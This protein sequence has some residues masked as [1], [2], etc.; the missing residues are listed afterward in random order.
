[1]STPTEEP[2]NSVDPV[3]HVSHQTH[4]R[5]GPDHH[6][7][8]RDNETIR[9]PYV[10][11]RAR[12]P[13][14]AE[15]PPAE[16]DPRQSPYAPKKARTQPAAGG[17]DGSIRDDGVPLVP[18]PGPEHSREH[19]ERYAVAANES[20]LFPHNPDSDSLLQP[21][22]SNSRRHE[23]PAAGRADASIR[24]LKRLES[25]LRWIQREE[26]VVRIPRAAQ[27][28]PVSGLAPADARGRRH[29]SEEL[30]SPRSLEP[31]RM[32]PPPPMRSRRR[33]LRAALIILIASIF[34]APIGYYLSVRAWGPPPQPAPGAQMA[35]LGPKTD[36]PPASIRQRTMTRDDDRGMS[37]QGE[38]S[39]QRSE[40][41]TV[42][43]VQPSA[44]GAQGPPSS[45]A[46]RVPDPEE[47]KLLMK[48]GEQLIAAGDVVTARVVFQRAADA[49]NANAAMA[50]GATYDPNVLRKLGVVGV[51]ADLEQARS[52]YRKAENLGSPD[53]RGR[54][55]GLP[56]H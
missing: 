14:S 38:I 56:D 1:M 47:I 29:G 46:V 27:L 4:E 50:L 26:A 16:N 18:P 9:S 15:R 53:A 20:Y 21:A 22:P 28:P 25:T 17:P 52:W 13:A 7:A 34:A 49:G 24:D 44:T 23:Q 51:S 5:A 3:A 45:K 31:E 43:M 12:E 19:P 33:K 39:S 37:A 48:Q 36:A 42:A 10:P 30:R 40:G 6:P 55:D 54:L 8:E 41:E 11:T 35:S 2:V 32:G